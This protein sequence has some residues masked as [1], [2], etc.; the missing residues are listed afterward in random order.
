MR[1]ALSLPG[2]TAFNS[3][4]TTWPRLAASPVLWQAA[5]FFTNTSRPRARFPSVFPSRTVFWYRFTTSSRALPAVVNNLVARAFSA[6]CRLFSRAVRLAASTSAAGT[7]PVSRAVKRLCAPC[8]PEINWASSSARA[9]GARLGRQTAICA[10]RG[11]SLRPARAATAA[12]CTAG[13]FLLLSRSLDKSRHTVLGA[14]A[15]VLTAVSRSFSLISGLPAVMAADRSSGSN[16]ARGDCWLPPS[17]PGPGVHQPSMLWPAC[18]MPWLRP[19]R[20]GARQVGFDSDSNARERASSGMA[21]AGGRAPTCMP[22]WVI[23]LAR[24]AFSGCP[25]ASWAQTARYFDRSGAAELQAA[26]TIQ[27]SSAS[28]HRRLAS[29]SS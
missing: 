13:G 24:A 18:R 5:Q 16:A 12:N 9:P 4:P 1:A 17:L 23:S 3:G 27:M 28:R 8:G 2:S 11:A 6:G 15:R 10:I 19:S 29:A 25:L 21:S 7:L 14:R 20:K 22:A 26:V